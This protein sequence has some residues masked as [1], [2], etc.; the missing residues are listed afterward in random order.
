MMDGSAVLY[1]R[2]VHSLV[3][4]G[5]RILQMTLKIFPDCKWIVVGGSPLSRLNASRYYERS[6]WVNRNVKSSVLHITLCDLH[7]TNCG[8]PSGGSLSS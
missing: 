5:C 6:A 4:N 7:S 1:L 3:A 2:D 8:W